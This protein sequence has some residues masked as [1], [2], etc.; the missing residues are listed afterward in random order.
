MVT[1]PTPPQPAS[2]AKSVAPQSGAAMSPVVLQLPQRLRR[3]VAMRN[4]PTIRRELAHVH[5]IDL[6]E[7]L[8]EHLELQQ[9]LVV[10][11]SLRVSQSASVLLNFTDALRFKCLEELPPGLSSQMLR[12]LPADEAVDMLQE[13]DSDQSRK[14]LSQMPFD[15]DTQTIHHLLLEDPDSAAGLMTTDYVSV[16]IDKT[17]ADALAEIRTA[18]RNDF[19]Y[20]CYLVNRE[21]QLVGVASLKG[22]LGHPEDT[23]L[24]QVATFDVKSILVSYD[25]EFVVNL[26]RKYDTLLAIPVVEHDDTLRGIVTLD[27]VISLVEEEA[28]EDIYRY[29]GINIEEIDE[30]NLLTGPIIKAVQARMPWLCITLFGQFIAATIIA[31]YSQTVSKATI[32]ISFMPLLTGL[33]GNMGTQS[34]TIS[35]RGLSLNLLNHDNFWSK[36]RREMRVA[37]SIGIIFALTIGGLTYFQYHHWQ[38][39]VLLMIWITLAPCFSATIGLSIPFIYKSLLG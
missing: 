38:L 29:S 14:I 36:L 30:K 31:S 17:V 10:L 15:A 4:P 26:F 12:F 7:A 34:D 20:Y 5:P 32:A 6:S 8:E 3:L 35:V 33:S 22:L 13:L 2:Q 21:H 24:Q 37:L 18:D 19:I 23:P 28:S 9:I 1:K 25:Q 16:G 11:K 39:S 27:D